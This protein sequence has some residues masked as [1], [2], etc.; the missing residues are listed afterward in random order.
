MKSVDIIKQLVSG[1][2]MMGERKGQD[3]IS[4]WN[5]AKLL[6][7]G[8]ALPLNLDEAT[9]AFYRRLL[10]LKMDT[11]PTNADPGLEEKLLQDIDYFIYKAVQAVSFSFMLGCITESQNSKNE[12]KKL[13][14]YSD[15]VAAFLDDCTVPR[16]GA[17]VDRSALYVAYQFYCGENGRTAL[18]RNAFYKNLEDSKKI[19]STSS[20][21]KRYFRDIELI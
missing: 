10:I 11:K 6:F 12:V 13:Y 16:V 15:T 17:K 7:S 5:V 18:T 1:D 8:N 20:C 2:L 21:G 14:K 4:F 9:N 19:C 3:P